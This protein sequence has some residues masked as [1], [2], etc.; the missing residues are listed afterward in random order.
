MLENPSNPMYGLDLMDRCG[1]K[2]G[3]LYPLLARLAEA[4][5]LAAESEIVDPSI[6]GRPPRTYYRL[7]GA[8]EAAAHKAL[9]RLAA[10]APRTTLGWVAP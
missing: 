8:G 3:T 4:G 10:P 5:W 1:V 7:T 9:T 2:S 6:V